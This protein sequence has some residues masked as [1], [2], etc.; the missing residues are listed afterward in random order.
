MRWIDQAVD[1]AVRVAVTNIV[2]AAEAGDLIF[3][4]AGAIVSGAEMVSRATNPGLISRWVRRSSQPS[5][6]SHVRTQTGPTH[7]LG[8]SIQSTAP[9]MPRD[10]AFRHRPLWVRRLARARKQPLPRAHQY[11]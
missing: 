2:V 6:P 9:H 4:T 11:H 8:G 5:N 7:A 10:I 3:L 1:D